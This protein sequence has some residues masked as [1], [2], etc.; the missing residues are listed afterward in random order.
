MRK[1]LEIIWRVVSKTAIKILYNYDEFKVIFTRVLNAHAPKNR[2]SLGEINS[3][4]NLIKSIY[5]SLKLKHLYNKKPAE[6]TK[7]NYKKKRNFCVNLLKREKRNL[8]IKVL[9]GN[10]KFRQSIKPIFPNKQKRL[11]KDTTIVDKDIIIPKN[12]KVAEKLNNFFINAVTN[13]DIPLQII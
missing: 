1:I 3:P 7:T 5:A 13:L 9:D 11:Q 10:K 6:M 2:G 8:D 12:N 4:S